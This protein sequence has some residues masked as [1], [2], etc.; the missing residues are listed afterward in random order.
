M[1]FER[2]SPLINALH[3]DYLSIRQQFSSILASAAAARMVSPTCII[4]AS[5]FLTMLLIDCFFQ[6]S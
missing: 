5:S 4:L 2:Y 3:V 6:D 1:I